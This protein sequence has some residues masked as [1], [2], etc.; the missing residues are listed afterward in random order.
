MAY[1][2]RCAAFEL[3][4]ATNECFRIVSEHDAALQ[5]AQLE[6]RD[7]K[8]KLAELAA[9]ANDLCNNDMSEFD[10]FKALFYAVIAAAEE[11]K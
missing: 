10:A 2:D 7:I 9:L 8:Q 3:A 11:G 1:C 4:L 6:L 5:K